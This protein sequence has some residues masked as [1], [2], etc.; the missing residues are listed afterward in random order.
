MT[1]PPPRLDLPT[2]CSIAV[3]GYL[4]ANVLHEG[5]GHAVV[6][7]AVG[8]TP[9]I[10][11]TAHVEWEA[12]SASEAA[13][14]LISAGGTL[15]NLLAGLAFAALLQNARKAAGSVRYFLWVSMSV[16]LFVGAGYFLFSGVIG[17]GD[18]ISVIHGWG[19]PAVWRATLVLVGVLLYVGAVAY[20]LRRLAP[21]IG[22]D[23]PAAV[24]RAVRLTT[25]PYV[26]ASVASSLGSLF[27]PIGVALFAISLAA[28]AGGTSA[29]AWMAQ[30]FE[31]RW[32]PLTDAEPIEI[33]RRWNWI[34]GAVVLLLVHVVV[35]GPGIRFGQP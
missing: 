13:R 19:R 21:L 20:S 16:N 15:V 29:L 31:T 1:R 25:V 17:I 28:H 8:C 30:M 22:G 23:K 35:L 4:I 26:L 2:I 7:Q 34:I 12:G 14:R 11:T 27:N 5:V 18:W 3:V 6:C 24:G 32:F 33:P 9:Q 10:V